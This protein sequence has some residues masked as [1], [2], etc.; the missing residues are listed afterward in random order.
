MIGFSLVIFIVI[1]LFETQREL[2]RQQDI[3]APGTTAEGTAGAAHQ[4]TAATGE[5]VTLLGRLKEHY[6]A[7][8]LPMGWRVAGLDAPTELA[9]TVRIVFSPSP[10]DRRYGQS[11]PVDDI[12]TDAFCPAGPQF[13]VGLEDRLVTVE[14]SDK[15]GAVK[16]LHC[17]VTIK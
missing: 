6:R 3:A 1:V 5:P 10:Q 4:A 15:N 2:A 9:A 7:Y 14:L 13:W 11:A 8:D 16:T 12:A 17:T